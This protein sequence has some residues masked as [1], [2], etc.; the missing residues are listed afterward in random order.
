V[1]AGS[2]LACAVVAGGFAASG[3]LPWN[4][5]PGP[6]FTGDGDEIALAA[7]APRPVA[8]AIEMPASGVAGASAG[9]AVPVAVRRPA[10][11]TTIG[12]TSTP[13]SGRRAERTNRTTSR[14][15]RSRTRAGD[16]RPPATA[17]ATT[18]APPSAAAPAVAAAPAPVARASSRK[19]KI[20]NVT[21]SFASASQ[22][23]SGQPELRVQMA[24]ADVAASA[25]ATPV[26]APTT[27]ALSLRL[28]QSQVEAID[29]RAVSAGDGADAPRV[30]LSAQVDV[31]DASSATVAG[32]PACVDGTCVR[33]QM[34][35]APATTAP[36]DS[37]PK[38]EVIEDDQA[39]SNSVKV[40]V[41]ID[42]SDLAATPDDGDHGGDGRPSDPP[43]A[44]ATTSVVSL[45]LTPSSPESTTPPAPSTDSA[46]VTVPDAGSPTPGAADPVAV[47]VQ[48]QL[49][50]ID[51]PPVPETVAPPAPAAQPTQDDPDAGVAMSEPD[52]GSG[53]DAAQPATAAPAATPATPSTPDTAAPVAPAGEH[54]GGQGCQ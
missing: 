52:S 33:V 26:A 24:L 2:C 21:T 30:A 48:A 14:P 11:T 46:T 37:A 9:T 49:E 51:P 40:T 16:Q 4:G 12:P 39:L 17:P 43:P 3:A 25:P 28:S 5:W 19:V 44:D 41:P 20:S 1:A 45:P 53:D 34:T 18:P 35:L 6:L 27:V 7:P 23:A 47:T 31:V 36:A 38:V 32:Q 29:A 54:E 22:T 13:G 8:P 50:V 10:G 15:P 42:T